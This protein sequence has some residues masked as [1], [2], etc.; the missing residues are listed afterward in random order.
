MTTGSA[1]HSHIDR[2]AQVIKSFTIVATAA[3]VREVE[4]GAVAVTAQ[5]S[6]MCL[7]TPGIGQVTPSTRPMIDPNAPFPVARRAPH[8]LPL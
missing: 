2:P 1:T 3:T 7:Q 4:H 8:P 5:V 6:A